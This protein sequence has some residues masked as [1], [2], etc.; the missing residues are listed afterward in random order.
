M[1]SIK[2]AVQYRHEAVASITVRHHLREVGELGTIA[3]YQEFDMRVKG[4]T[5]W[6]FVNLAIIKIS[7]FR[8]ILTLI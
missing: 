7:A 2:V 4:L 8:W 5:G 6:G 3:E 1:A